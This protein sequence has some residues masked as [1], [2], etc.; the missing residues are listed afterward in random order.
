M[1]QTTI[2]FTPQTW[3]DL[4]RE[5][6]ALGVSAAQYVRDATVAQLAYGAGRRGA[7]AEADERAAVKARAGIAE[8]GSVESL[9]GAE[10]VRAQ[11]Q[12]ARAR[13][14]STR[15]VARLI[16]TQRRP[17]EFH[18]GNGSGRQID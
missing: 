16:Q 9:A 10:A 1:H 6:R 14:R 7:L 5:A 15:E 17:A 8:L 18:L 12:L 13:A 11:A 2:R 4:E 3:R